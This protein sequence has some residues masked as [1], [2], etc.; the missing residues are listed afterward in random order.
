MSCGRHK[1]AMGRLHTMS[2]I[3]ELE[4]S[5]GWT[6]PPK[7]QIDF[8]F[9]AEFRFFEMTPFFL[10]SPCVISSAGAIV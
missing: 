3:V 9:E 7:D 4:W 8:I 10:F 6:C 2:S 1:L 5:Y